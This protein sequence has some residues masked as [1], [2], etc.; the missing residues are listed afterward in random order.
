V[1]R[2]LFIAATFRQGVFYSLTQR[3]TF[4]V[5]N[6]NHSGGAG[7]LRAKNDA[8]ESRRDA[9]MRIVRRPEAS[10]HALP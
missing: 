6:T 3:I 10:T 5:R 7:I 2:F 8:E 9:R 1:G 4:S